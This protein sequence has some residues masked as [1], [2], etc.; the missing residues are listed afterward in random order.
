M[1]N[2]DISY[3]PESWGV[4][5]EGKSPPLLIREDEKKTSVSTFLG[6][7]SISVY[8]STGT[9]RLQGSQGVVNIDGEIAGDAENAPFPWR[10][11][12]RKNHHQE[13]NTNAVFR[14]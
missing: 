11:F 13:Y 12:Q 8:Q 5:D 9:L 10:N 2:I 14:N 3:I 7:L 4:Q 1:G 6:D